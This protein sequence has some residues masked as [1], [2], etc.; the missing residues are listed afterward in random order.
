MAKCEHCVA[1]EIDRGKLNF[2]TENTIIENAQKRILNNYRNGDM[3]FKVKNFVPTISYEYYFKFFKYCHKCGTKINS[4]DIRKSINSKV[5]K[6][7]DS[8]DKDKYKQ[9]LKEIESKSKKAKDKVIPENFPK[10]SSGYIYIIKMEKYYKIGLSRSIAVR[11]NS[12]KSLP[13]KIEILALEQVVDDRSVESELHKMFV[14]KR[15]N[16]EWFILDEDEIQSAITYLQSRKVEY[17][18]RK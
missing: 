4:K 6:Y 15:T 16:G 8:L 1:F 2:L 18:E 13:E 7:I 5:L 11:L 14:K 12:F 10:A 9:I 17:N 3:N